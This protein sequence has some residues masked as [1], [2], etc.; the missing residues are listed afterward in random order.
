VAGVLLSVFASAATAISFGQLARQGRG[1][2]GP[3]TALAARYAWMW[4]IGAVATAAFDV[5]LDHQGVPPSVNSILW[6][7][8]FLVVAG[9]LYLAGGAL[10][11]DTVMFALGGLTLAVAA[12]SS[13]AGVPGN[14]AVLCVAGGG[15]LLVAAA[16]LRPRSRQQP[17]AR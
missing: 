13:F 8:S 17:C 7:A 3:S 15:G 9:L 12:A 1:L 2:R 10:F 11:D 6:P 16:L 14:F 4:P 5:G